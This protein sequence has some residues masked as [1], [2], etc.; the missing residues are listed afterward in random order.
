[1][2]PFFKYLLLSFVLVAISLFSFVFDDE[3]N[4][5]ADKYF[6]D[7]IKKAGA[8]FV[9]ARGVNAA[10]S[11]AKSTQVSAEPM[12]VGV[13][14]GVG[15]VLDPVDDVIE[16]LSDVMFTAV[17]SL[18]IQ[19][20][21]YEVVALIGGNGLLILAG[22]L[23]LAYPLTRWRWGDWAC[24]HLLRVF[25]LLVL[26]RCLLPIC[27]LSNV[28]VDRYFFEPQMK[29]CDETLMIVDEQTAKFR[30]EI[31]GNNNHG[32][33]ERIDYSKRYLKQ[34]FRNASDIVEASI[35]LVGLVI[36]QFCFQVIVLPL[37]SFLIFRIAVKNLYKHRL[38]VFLKS[39][40][41]PRGN[42]NSDFKC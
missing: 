25:I 33:V 23:L 40:S 4:G 26:L 8:T 14:I 27:A 42:A 35:S 32:F 3:I 24:N 7:S 10:I 20:L 6:E 37:V 39:P 36:A 29:S 15:E 41:F 13:S 5:C 22:T 12:G 38:P 11:V 9:T 1:M 17:V 21:S 19:K 2:K 34:I 31:F 16:T 28:V 30:N 18:S